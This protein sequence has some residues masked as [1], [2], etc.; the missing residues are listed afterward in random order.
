MHL[1]TFLL[2]MEQGKLDVDLMIFSSINSIAKNKLIFSA[3]IGQRFAKLEVYVV[4]A[5]MV[6]KFKLG[7]Q[8]EDV[9]IKTG[10]VGAPNIEIVLSVRDR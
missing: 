10:L 7:Y 2:V 4:A 8:G 9:G 5:K 1:Q 3:C 6:F